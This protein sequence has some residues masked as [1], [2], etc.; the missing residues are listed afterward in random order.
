MLVPVLVLVLS[1]IDESLTFP[2]RVISPFPPV[3][4]VFRPLTWLG[5]FD[6]LPLLWLSGDSCGFGSVSRTVDF[7]LS[8]DDNRVDGMCDFCTVFIHTLPLLCSDN[9]IRFI[10]NGRRSSHFMA[11]GRASELS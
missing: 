9:A 10:N 2:E 6:I 4:S 8:D 5:S 11:A 7:C 3:L 1:H